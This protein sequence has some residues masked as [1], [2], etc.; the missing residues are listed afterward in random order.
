MTTK[1]RNRRTREQCKREA[2]KTAVMMIML[3][4]LGAVLM[5]W[6]LGVWTEHP[7]EQ[8]MSGSAYMASMTAE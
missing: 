7:G 6:A 1:T 4:A 5:V 3:F 2:V 8:P